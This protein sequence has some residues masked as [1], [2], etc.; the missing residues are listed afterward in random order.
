VSGTIRPPRSLAGLFGMTILYCAL[1]LLGGVAAVLVAHIVAGSAAAIAEGRGWLGWKMPGKIAAFNI[2]E[3]GSA[4][5][6]LWMAR[7]EGRIGGQGD[8][9]RG[10]GYLPIARRRDVAMLALAVVAYA[11]GLVLVGAYTD[12]LDGLPKMDYGIETSDLRETSAV[13]LLLLGLIVCVVAPVMEELIFRSWLWTG[14]RR[15]WGVVPTVLCTGGLFALA[16]VAVGIYK[17]LLVLPTAL[18]LS[19]VRHF[20]GS[21]RASIAAHI[22]NNTVATGIDILLFLSDQG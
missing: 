1:T 21:V 18:L 13:S 5:V 15:Y 9:R 19:L 16:H 12:W 3:L 11:L 8:I 14:L 20:G 6:V 4:A 7:R 2:G 10:L 17:P 22:L